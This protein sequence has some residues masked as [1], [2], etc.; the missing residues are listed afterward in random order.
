M[1]S[2]QEQISNLTYFDIFLEE[3]EEDE[4][5]KYVRSTQCYANHRDKNSKDRAAYIQGTV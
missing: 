5:V 2:R 1:S 3:V 4:E